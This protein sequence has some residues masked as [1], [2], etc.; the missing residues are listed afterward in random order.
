MEQ[1]IGIGVSVVVIYATVAFIGRKFRI[2]AR[3][4]RKPRIL[5]TWSALDNGIDPTETDQQ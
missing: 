5:N 4:E 3:Y 2:S 1:S